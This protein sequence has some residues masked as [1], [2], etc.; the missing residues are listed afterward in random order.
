MGFEP[1]DMSGA[2]FKNERKQNPNQPDYRGDAMIEGIQYEIGAWVKEA[3]STGKQFMSLS[4]KVKAEREDGPGDY[5]APRSAPQGFPGRSQG[6]R[7]ALP[8]DDDGFLP[9]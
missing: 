9:F 1:R 7:P 8:P 5:R 2:L 6:Y 4:F 3:K